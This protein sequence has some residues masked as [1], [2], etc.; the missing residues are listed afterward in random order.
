MSSR[1]TTRAIVEWAQPCQRSETV[2]NRQEGR[3]VNRVSWRRRI[4]AVRVWCCGERTCIAAAKM[5]NK[6][7]SVAVGKSSR[8]REKGKSLCMWKRGMARQGEGGK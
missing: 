1:T 8:S 6:R 5:S 7:S 2:E 3:S 4:G